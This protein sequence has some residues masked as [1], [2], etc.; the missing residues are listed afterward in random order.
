M[1]APIQGWIPDADDT[2]IGVLVDVQNMI[3]TVRGY[4]GAPSPLPVNLPALASECR[5]SAMV[6][7][8]NDASV[9]FA[10]TQ[11]GLYKASGSTWEDVSKSGGYTGSTASRWVFT[12]Q[13]DVTIAVNKTDA[14][15]YYLHGTSTDFANVT[16]MP[17]ALVAE[18]VGN[19]VLIGNY[20]NGSEVSDGWA[21]SAIADYTDW[22][23]SINTQCTYGR[24]YDT[25]GEV[26]GIK[27]L[28]DYAIF[29]KSKAMYLARYVGVPSVWDFSLVSDSIG[30]ASQDAIARVGQVHYF[31]G[32][33]NFYAFDSNSIQ[34]IGDPIKEWFYSQI[35][36][37]KR[38]LIQSV[39]DKQKNIVYWLYPTGS[40]SEITDWVSFNYKTQKWGKGQLTIESSVQY[41]ASGANYDDIG[42]LFASYDAITSDYDS[43]SPAGNYSIPAIFDS[44]HKLNTLNGPCVNSS[45][46]SN[47]FGADGKITLLSRVRP[48]YMN[49]PDSATLTN[50]YRD[51]M[52]QD[53]NNGITVNSFNGKFDLLK[54]SRWHRIKID[55]IGDYEITGAD[56]SISEDGLE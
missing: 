49:S 2:A 41:V 44:T 25:P 21:C 15:Q 5:G 36:P 3:P 22:T 47:D 39:H 10:G 53:I 9:L 42:T 28:A 17:K 8:L 32:E 46:T 31:V 20:N 35:N 29:Y 11:T 33:D 37:E 51:E 50:Y 12:Q 1:Y 43:V 40:S 16:G 13:G 18:T 23:P 27:R 34:P 26:R 30:C 6:N 7:T 54:S 52:G 48:R 45:F 14:S 55:L 19:F 38:T 24:L 56:I 4:A